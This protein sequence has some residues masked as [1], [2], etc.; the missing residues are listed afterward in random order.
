MERRQS[1][2][3]QTLK[4]RRRELRESATETETILWPLLQVL[5]LQGTIFRR[6]HSVGPY[7]ADFCCPARKLIIEL[8]GGVHDKEFQKQYDEE[9]TKY[10]NSR[11]FRV[12]R[13]TNEEVKSNPVAIVETIRLISPK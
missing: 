9:R 5:R 3:R 6:Q 1:A 7:I 10:L 11:G 4:D 13:F 12:V 2:L 8:D